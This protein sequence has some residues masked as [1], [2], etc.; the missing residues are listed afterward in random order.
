MGDTSNDALL[1]CCLAGS[2]LLFTP[3]KADGPNDEIV[4]WDIDSK[5]ELGR[6]HGDARQI[7][8]SIIA[9]SR[10]RLALTSDGFTL[11]VW[12]VATRECR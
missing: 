6:L 8:S 10:G 1:P 2:V 7:I 12:D 4:M 5:T 3:E 9:D 11:R